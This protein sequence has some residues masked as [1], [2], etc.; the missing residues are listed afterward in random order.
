MGEE[1]NSP[2]PGLS[3]LEIIDELVEFEVLGVPIK[4]KMISGEEYA[5][6]MDQSSN[7]Q[8]LNRALYGRLL[9]STCVI[10]PKGIDSR[11]LKAAAWA[12][13]V[14]GLEDELG[15]SEVARKKFESR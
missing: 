14:T 2:Q 8:E 4:A 3:D 1:K 6:I 15:F 9:I 11:K 13:I 7:G 12:L 5:D 10:E